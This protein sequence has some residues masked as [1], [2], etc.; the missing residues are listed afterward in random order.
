MLALDLGWLAMAVL[1]FGGVYAKSSFVWY[2][3]IYESLPWLA[4][5]AKVGSIVCAGLILL[6]AGVSWLATL[7]RAEPDI[8][9]DSA[10]AS[11]AK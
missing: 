4:S 10:V 6:L 11:P 3:G 8:P 9:L 5:L 1:W 7:K 2:G